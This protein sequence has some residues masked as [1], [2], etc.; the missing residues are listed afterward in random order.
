MAI[1]NDDLANLAEPVLPEQLVDSAIAGIPRRLVVH[2]DLNVV[3]ARSAADGQSI[4]HRKR[5]G[6]FDHDVEVMGGGRFDDAA[7][8]SDGGVHEQR[9]RL[10]VREEVVEGRVEELRVEVELF[11]VFAAQ[12]RV[13][14]HDAHQLCVLLLRKLL[15]ESDDV[16][17]L[18]ADDG[19]ANGLFSR[20]C[21]LRLREGKRRAGQE[22][23]DENR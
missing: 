2:Q 7:V 11:L 8:L 17:M 6:L 4:V 20:S 16:P 14:V 23:R 10:L 1:M 3:L 15:Q 19:D 9:L 13:G 22:N 21:C 12:R 18:E 5:E